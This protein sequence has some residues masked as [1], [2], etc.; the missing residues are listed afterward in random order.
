[1]VKETNEKTVIVKEKMKAAQDR[2]KSYADQ[3]HKDKEFR[4]GEYILLEVSPI[5]G[6]VRF[7]QKKDKLSPHYI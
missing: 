1:M 2:H 5:R 6:V 4:V 3:H 7:G